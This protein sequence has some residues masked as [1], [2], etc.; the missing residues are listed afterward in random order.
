MNAIE[1]PLIFKGIGV[2]ID[3]CIHEQEET[4][5]LIVNLL[6]QTREVGVPCVL[7]NALPPQAELAHFTNVAFVLLDW[8]LWEK[9]STER[10]TEGVHA[11]DE[12]QQQGIRANIEFLNKLREICFAPV[13]IFSHLDPDRIKDSLRKAGLL[14]GQESAAFIL[15]K[16]KSELRRTAELPGFPLFDAIDLWVHANP[17]IYTLS[18]WR[19]AFTRS[20]NTLFWDLYN[21]NPAWPSVL[22]KAYEKDND[23]PEHGL[24]D[25]LLRNMRARLLPLSLDPKSVSPGALPVPNQ[26]SLRAVLER[27]MIVP[28]THLTANKYASGDLFRSPSPDSTYWL[29]I[30]CDCDCAPRNGKGPASTILYLLEAKARTDKTLRKEECFDKDF[31]LLPGRHNI[32]LLFP[33]DG[34]LL[35]VEFKDLHQKSAGDLLSSGAKRIGRIT[36]PH[37]TYIRQR[38]ALYL[39]R[40]GLP[41]I[42]N[43]AVYTDHEPEDQADPPRSRRNGQAPRC[44]C[45][46]PKPVVP[47]S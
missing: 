47:A 36:P 2:V 45:P 23:D 10:V 30:R 22:W 16:A 43:E 21:Q 24:A 8:E 39:Q 12:L 31:G 28:E 42:P 4:K 44:N 18:K 17:A 9:P 6:Q 11:G 34:Q 46:R 29:N 13:F 15:V 33:V 7:Y 14:Q 40:E 25:I 20:Q 38:F 1:E 37:I 35:Q 41:R 26:A 19:D 5:D 27:A 32:G 3:D